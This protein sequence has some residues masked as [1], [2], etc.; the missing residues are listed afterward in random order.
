MSARNVLFPL[1]AVLV[2]VLRNAG[3]GPLRFRLDPDQCRSWVIQRLPKVYILSLG[4]DFMATVRSVPFR[5]L[6]SLALMLDDLP[7]AAAVVSTKADFTLGRCHRSSGIADSRE[8]VIEGILEPHTVKDHDS[9]APDIRIGFLRPMV[10][11]SGNT[12]ETIL[13]H[14]PKVGR[15]KTRRCH[16]LV[17]ITE[18]R[19]R[20]K[21]LSCRRSPS[22]VRDFYNVPHE[23][24]QVKEDGYRDRLFPMCVYEQGAEDPTVRM[25]LL[26]EAS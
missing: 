15:P 5:Q 24:F 25:R 6:C 19:K 16:L 9:P 1:V 26:E 21:R 17:E 2:M 3:W 18:Y 11:T 12:I 23:L 7:P 4:V 20:D 22:R 8:I 13:K 14:I 10:A